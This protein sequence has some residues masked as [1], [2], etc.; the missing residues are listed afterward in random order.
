[1]LLQIYGETERA[2]IT[3][4]TLLD[5]SRTRPS[6]KS[7]FPLLPLI[8]ETLVLFQGK[9]GR[10]VA[11]TIRIPDGLEV[12]GDRHRLQQ[13]FVNLIK[14]ALDSMEGHGAVVIEAVEGSPQGTL[15]DER[16]WTPCSLRAA[17]NGHYVDIAVT[18]T[19]SGIQGAHLTKIF[20]PFFTTK[21]VGQGT[22]LGL[23]I[24]REIIDEHG[25]AIFV[26]SDQGKGATFILRL[27]TRGGAARCVF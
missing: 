23:F 15:S 7:V 8:R 17:K 4:R 22:G 19:G 12:F 2:R 18:D 20:D 21:D 3:I 25:G 16:I 26:R 13:V 11:V 1:M 6:E 9:F 14:N 5:Y 10:D 27:P 24:V